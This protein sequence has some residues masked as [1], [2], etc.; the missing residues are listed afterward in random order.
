M[1]LTSNKAISFVGCVL[2]ASNV[3]ATKIASKFFLVLVIATAHSV[4]VS[5]SKA[6]TR[7]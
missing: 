5:S 7:S 6:I 4:E 3:I 2:P 1:R